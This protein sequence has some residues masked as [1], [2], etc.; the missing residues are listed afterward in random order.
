MPRTGSRL[1]TP[2]PCGVWG[3]GL[4]SR[5]FPGFAT[6]SQDEK[7]RVERS[8]LKFASVG[9]Q[10]AA[11]I[12]IFTYAGIW[13]DGKTGWGPLFTILGV[14]LGFTGATTS[15]YFKVY[16]QRKTQDRNGR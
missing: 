6:Q 12:L 9:I 13:L 3:R 2:I 7:K 11:A 8:Y 10:F 16:G 1:G 14:L 4:S 5:R 15:L